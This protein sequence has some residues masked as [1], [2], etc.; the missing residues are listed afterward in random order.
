MR[1]RAPHEDEVR[2]ATLAPVPTRYLIIG[3]LAT[4]LVILA[5]VGA[6]FLLGLL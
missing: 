5:G 6:W 2:A 1:K 3:A 4:A